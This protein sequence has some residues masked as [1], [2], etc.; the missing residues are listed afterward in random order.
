MTDFEVAIINAIKEIIGEDKVKCCFFHFSQNIF[1]RIQA[2][3]LQTA[4][5][6]PETL[7]KL[8][9]Q[10]LCA[11]AFTPT[12]DI[13]ANFR[14][15]KDYIASELAPIYS[16]FESTHVGATRRG[17]GGRVAPRYQPPIWS[18]YSSVLEK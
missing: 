1:R 15:L 6:E 11:L 16:Y 14:A 4:Y 17:R 9:A 5:N 13:P 8:G 18:Q 7:V 10:M 2:E 3:G 12:E